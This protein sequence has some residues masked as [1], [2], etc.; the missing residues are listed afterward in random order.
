MRERESP[1]NT[2]S[3]HNDVLVYEQLYEVLILIE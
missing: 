2:D 3:D 1:G